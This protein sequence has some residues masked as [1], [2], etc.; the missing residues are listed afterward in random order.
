MSRPRLDLPLPNYEREINR[1][2]RTYRNAMKEVQF[3]IEELATYGKEKDI[4][5]QQVNSTI[6][7]LSV[8]LNELDEE[9]EEW[10]KEYI[11]NM[12]KDGQAEAIFALGDAR[13]LSE[14]A[15]HAKMSRLARTTIEALIDDTFE[16]LL[17]ANQKMK[18]ETI[19]M[20][21]SVVADTMRRQAAQGQGRRTTRRRLVETLTKKEL[22]ER[23]NVEGN[24]GIVDSLGRQWKLDTYAEMVTLPN[25]NK[26]TLKGRELNRHKER[27]TLQSYLHMGLLTLVSILRAW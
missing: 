2:I 19:K 4:S 16:D 24:V 5:R 9:A 18:R 15:K 6:R 11:P 27:L 7:Q 1:L 26:H 21:R 14:A 23:W 25:Y 17:Y 22:R 3:E 8:L 20:V 12:F 10:V 13:T